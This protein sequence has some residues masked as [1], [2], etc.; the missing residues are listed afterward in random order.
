MHLLWQYVYSRP[1]ALKVPVHKG[2]FCGKA[3]QNCSSPNLSQAQLATAAGRLFFHYILLSRVLRSLMKNVSN[4]SK[5]L[6]WEVETAVRVTWQLQ[7]TLGAIQMLLPQCYWACSSEVTPCNSAGCMAQ[8]LHP[9]QPQLE[10]E[11]AEHTLS[12]QKKHMYVGCQ[13]PIMAFVFLILSPSVALI[14]PSFR[15]THL[16][17]QFVYCAGNTLFSLLPV[18]LGHGVLQILLQL[19][20]QLNGR[21]KCNDITR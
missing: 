17:L 5:T 1:H 12:I 7:F 21:D 13:E 11:G 19:H 20:A 8:V 15:D 14:L 16:L 2:L 4:F 18:L 10:S 3:C 6:K 9:N